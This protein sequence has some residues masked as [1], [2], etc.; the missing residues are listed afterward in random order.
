MDYAPCEALKKPVETEHG[1]LVPKCEIITVPS[2]CK[3]RRNQHCEVVKHHET[4]TKTAQKIYLP[5]ARFF[6]RSFG[7]IF[8]R[9]FGI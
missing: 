7:G 8:L 6:D 1:K 2:G 5:N 3:K 4:H 9:F